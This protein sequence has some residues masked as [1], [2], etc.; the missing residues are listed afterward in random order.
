MLE[1]GGE[2]GGEFKAGE[3]GSARIGRGGKS[4]LRVFDDGFEEV[5]EVEFGPGEATDDEREEGDAEGPDVAKR[6]MEFSLLD[7]VASSV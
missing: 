7:C 5:E 4:D 6:A 3:E 2:G 1:G